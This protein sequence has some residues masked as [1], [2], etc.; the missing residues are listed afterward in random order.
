MARSDVYRAVLST[1]LPGDT[2]TLLLGA[3]LLDGGDARRAW[4]SLVGAGVDVS[5]LLTRGGHGMRRLAPLLY[6]AL[7]RHGLDA[8]SGL[9]TRCRMASMREGLRARAF[10]RA[11]RGAFDVLEDAEIPFI[12]LKGAALAEPVY[13]NP[14]LRHSHDLELLVPSA[15]VQRAASALRAIGCEGT[16][17]LRAGGKLRVH[18]ESGLPI[19]LRTRLFEPELYGGDWEWCS[20][21]TA[22]VNVAERKVL[23]LSPGLALHHVC[24]NATYGHGRS[25]LQW[26]T[27]AIMLIRRCGDPRSDLY[28][29]WRDVTAC[30]GRSRTGLPLATVFGYLQRDLHADIPTRVMRAV[31]RAAATAPGLEREVALRCVWWG[32][33]KDFA[34]ALR[35]DMGW[36]DRIRIAWRILAPSQAY[37]AY[38]LGT[39]PSLLA[40]TAYYARRATRQTARILA[41]QF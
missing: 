18:H 41:G 31:Q 36:L 10:A 29:D 14:V 11:A 19:V 28:L 27:D 8:D 34:R 6:E 4:R 12:V 30:V 15:E 40:L 38:R 3:C 23:T 26:V 17:P 33:P 13:G 2:E 22:S 21:R 24:V 35:A 39:R 1:N 20:E 37:A 7:R 32:R 9:L 5:E 16:E 25:S